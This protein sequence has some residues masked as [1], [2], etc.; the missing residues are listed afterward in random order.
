VLDRALAAAEE[1]A[2]L[3]T[4]PNQRAASDGQIERLR[5]IASLP[6]Q[7]LRPLFFDFQWPAATRQQRR[8][9]E[10]ARRIEARAAANAKI[11][12]SDAQGKI[13]EFDAF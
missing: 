13:L 4:L 3:Q 9:A 1:D 2:A 8:L 12:V 10:T 5:R 7:T 11:R 6:D